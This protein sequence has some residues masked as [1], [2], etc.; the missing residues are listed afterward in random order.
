MLHVFHRREATQVQTELTHLSVKNKEHVCQS[1][2]TFLLLTYN[3][4]KKKHA[5]YIISSPSFCI[6]ESYTK[7]QTEYTN[8]FTRLKR[9]IF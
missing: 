6:V 4:E 9:K 1:P 7:V 8:I 3:T 2:H 5:T